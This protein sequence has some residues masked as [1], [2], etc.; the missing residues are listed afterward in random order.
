MIDFLKALNAIIHTSY[1][2]LIVLL[3]EMAQNI[4]KHLLDL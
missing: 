4:V 3:L 2:I 1:L